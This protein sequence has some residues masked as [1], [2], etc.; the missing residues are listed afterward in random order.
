MLK[1]T[2]LDG[3]KSVARM[4]LLTPVHKTP[5]SPAVVPALKVNKAGSTQQVTLHVL[6]APKNASKSPK[7]AQVPHET[8]HSM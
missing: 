7:T 3:V 8:M 6:P 5:Y 1:E 4:L 2:N